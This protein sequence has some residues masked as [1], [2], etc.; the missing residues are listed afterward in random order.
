M[1]LAEI[2]AVVR[3]TIHD[4]VADASVSLVNQPSLDFPSLLPFLLVIKRQNWSRTK[5]VLTLSKSEWPAPKPFINNKLIR[6]NATFGPIEQLHNWYRSLKLCLWRAVFIHHQQQITPGHTK[7]KVT[8]ICYQQRSSGERERELLLETISASD[9]SGRSWH[10][11]NEAKWS[12][13]SLPG[14]SYPKP[15]SSFRT[16][17]C[18]IPALT[19]SAGNAHWK[20][21]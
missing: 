14:I 5:Q 15:Y 20:G 4:V 7:L 16:S 17:Y 9:P 10:M 18:P 19:A 13:S 2:P 1:W 11:M 3:E 12:L 8:Q 6:L 21:S